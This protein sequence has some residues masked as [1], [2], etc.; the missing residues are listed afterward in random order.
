MASISSRYHHRTVF[1]LLLLLLNVAQLLN[2]HASTTEALHQP[3]AKGLFSVF[4]QDCQQMGARL[5]LP[6]NHERKDLVT[7][8]TK[9]LTYSF[10]DAFV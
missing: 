2:M 5:T 7:W 1:L 10:A 6:W 9:R 4:G 3:S 8:M